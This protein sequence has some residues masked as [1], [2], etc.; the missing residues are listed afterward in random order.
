[1][2]MKS[3]QIS[4]GGVKYNG[5]YE[6]DGKDVCVSSAY[7]SRRL[8]RA[9]GKAADVAAAGL[10]QIVDAWAPSRV[11]LSAARDTSRAT[12]RR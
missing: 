1:M 5:T 8:P 9:R 6:E 11:G 10:H 12:R 4:H 3:I 2:T 7:G